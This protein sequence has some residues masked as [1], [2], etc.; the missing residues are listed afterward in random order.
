VKKIAV[1]ADEV[2]VNAA[3]AALVALT[4]QVPDDPTAKFG[5]KIDPDNR[6]ELCT[7]GSNV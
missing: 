1:V 5:V 6:Q 3:S 7:S 4:K 2:A